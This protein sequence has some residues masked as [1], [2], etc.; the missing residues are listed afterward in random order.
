MVRAVDSDRILVYFY[1]SINDRLDATF[2]CHRD[3]A[4][5]QNI[6]RFAYFGRRDMAWREPLEGAEMELT[7]T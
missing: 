6:S 4:V 5:E 3:I 2:G 7:L 1:L